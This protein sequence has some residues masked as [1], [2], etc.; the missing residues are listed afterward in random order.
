MRDEQ[1][2]T[3]VRELLAAA[4]EG[5]AGAAGQAE[6]TSR[7]NEKQAAFLRQWYAAWQRHLEY[8]GELHDYICM[9]EA[10]IEALEER[11]DENERKDENVAAAVI[12][13]MNQFH[14]DEYEDD[15]EN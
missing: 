7:V 14:D 4:P 15:E 12:W 8:M 3:A 6:S 11:L 10:R 2:A 9:L 5:P 1:R 13:L